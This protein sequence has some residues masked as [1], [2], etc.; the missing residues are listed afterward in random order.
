M[1]W[2]R[3]EPVKDL[4][5]IVVAWFGVTL[6]KAVA[7]VGCLLSNNCT[8]GNHFLIQLIRMEIKRQAKNREFETNHW[9]R[10]ALT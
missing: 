3:L 1:V 6:T 5:L 10:Q 4:M 8:C 2:Y 7:R 9:N